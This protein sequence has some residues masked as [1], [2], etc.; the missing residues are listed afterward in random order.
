[1]SEATHREH[2]EFLLGEGRK[3][4]EQLAGASTQRRDELGK[5]LMGTWAQAQVHATLALAEANATKP[6]FAVGDTI[7]AYSSTGL[8]L[9]SG[10]PFVVDASGFALMHGHEMR[11]VPWHAVGYVGIDD[12]ANRPGEPKREG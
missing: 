4:A 12:H 11:V 3:I 7:R 2:A 10:K 6:M 8:G 9:A 5:Q 1:M